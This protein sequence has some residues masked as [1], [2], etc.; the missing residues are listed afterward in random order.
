MAFGTKLT[1]KGFLGSVI[2]LAT[3]GWLQLS[4]RGAGG[5]RDFCDYPH[6]VKL[7]TKGRIGS[8]LGVATLGTY[9]KICIDD[10]FQTTGPAMRGFRKEEIKKRKINVCVEVY[11]KKF[12]HEEI[13]SLDHKITVKDLEI[14]ELGNQEISIKV[15]RLP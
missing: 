10:S 7:A 2:S 1:S 11:G 13:V 8:G 14:T 15:K 5:P 12:C 6:A 9:F 4:R 3:K